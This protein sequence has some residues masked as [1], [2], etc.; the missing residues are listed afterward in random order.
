LAASAT[1]DAVGSAATVA[2]LATQAAERENQ[3]TS[4]INPEYVELSIQV[5]LQ[6]VIAAHD[7]T[8]NAALAALRDVLQPYT[9]ASCKA[10]VVLTF[11]HGGT[12]GQGTQLAAAINTLIQ[13]QYPGS[14][15]GAAFDSF[16]DL[17]APLGQVDI[18]IYFFSGCDPAEGS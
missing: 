4:S 10:G 11:G 13:D 16:G 15:D 14:F 7:P 18:R 12:I 8:V 6:G 5:D 1:A 9:Q 2:A 3:V 17:R